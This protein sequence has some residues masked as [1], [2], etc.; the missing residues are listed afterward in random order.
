MASLPE[1][2]IRLLPVAL[3][4]FKLELRLPLRFF[5][6]FVPGVGDQFPLSIEVNQEETYLMRGN[7]D[8]GGFRQRSASYGHVCDDCA[9]RVRRVAG[10]SPDTCFEDELLHLGGGS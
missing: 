9:D 3:H 1:R 2:L 8:P 5:D 6:R 10:H 7:S 4:D